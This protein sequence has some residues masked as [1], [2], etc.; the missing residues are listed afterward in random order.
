VGKPMKTFLEIQ[1][2]IRRLSEKSETEIRRLSEEAEKA[3]AREKGEVIERIRAAIDAY[4]LTASDLGLNAS[5]GRR[6]QETADTAPARKTASKQKKSA[7]PTKLPPKYADGAGNQW[8]G[9]G[10]RPKWF[11][12][13]LEAGR[14]EA[15]LLVK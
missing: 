4:G 7:T 13:A 11:L 12:A 15:D 1:A 5:R 10:S 14:S 6:G 8:S 9:R 3:K 2:E